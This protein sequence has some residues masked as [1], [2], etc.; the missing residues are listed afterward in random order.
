MKPTIQDRKS[1]QRVI[2]RYLKKSGIYTDYAFTLDWEELSEELRE[3]KIHSYV[4]FNYRG[5]YVKDEDQ[6]LS[7]DELVE[8]YRDEAEYQIKAHFPMYF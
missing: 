7:D 1:T 2:A 5:D 4:T 3:A 6:G 8:K